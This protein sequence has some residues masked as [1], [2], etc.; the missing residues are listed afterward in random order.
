MSELGVTAVGNEGPLS[1]LAPESQLNERPDRIFPPSLRN[2]GRLPIAAIG[3]N[4]NLFR[5]SVLLSFSASSALTS[6]PAD[7]THGNA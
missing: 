1:L 5:N 4:Q 3:A 6:S 7:F 2:L